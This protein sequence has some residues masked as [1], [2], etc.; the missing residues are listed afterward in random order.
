LTQSETSSTAKSLRW[1]AATSAESAQH[2]E[3]QL[4][5]LARLVGAL[6]LLRRTLAAI[7]ER[8]IETRAHQR[9]C[10]ARRG[11]YARERLGMSAS[12]ARALLLRAGH[13][14]AFERCLLHP[15]RAKD[16]IAPAERQ[17]CAPE[18][19]VEGTERLAWRV[20]C[21]VAAPFTAVRETVRSRLQDEFRDTDGRCPSHGEVFEATLECAL[22]AATLRDPGA[23]RTDPV[24]ERD[25]YRCAVPGRTSRRNLHDHHLGFRSAGGSNEPGNR[26]T[27]CAFHHQRCLH[28]GFLAIRDCAPNGLVFELGLRPGAPPLLRYRSGDVVVPEDRP[29]IQKCLWRAA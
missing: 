3:D 28:V 1:A 26:V 20:P 21:E 9:F 5:R 13:P 25:G 7:A 8:L 23:R 6:G 11:D 12:K 19:D 14:R 2:I 24:I 16:P 4:G 15:E 18:V 17:M 22:L 29:E 27:L 10:Y